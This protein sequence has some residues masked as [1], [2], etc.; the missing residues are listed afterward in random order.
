MQLATRIKQSR[1]QSQ[2]PLQFAVYIFAR[3][4]N[5]PWNFQTKEKRKKER[6]KIL[7]SFLFLLKTHL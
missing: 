7:L 1:N 5:A 2:V 6:E 4:M 3:E